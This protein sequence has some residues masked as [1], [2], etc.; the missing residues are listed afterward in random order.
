MFVLSVDADG[1]SWFYQIIGI[2]WILSDGRDGISS[3]YHMVVM[4]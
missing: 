2:S 3:F 1:I 4:G